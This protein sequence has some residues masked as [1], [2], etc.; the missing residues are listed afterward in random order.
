MRVERA[1]HADGP[2]PQAAAATFA[3]VRARQL[4][5]KTKRR[6][7]RLVPVGQLV[8]AD[9]RAVMALPQEDVLLGQQRGAGR[10][11]SPRRRTAPSSRSRRCATP[12]RCCARTSPAAAGLPPGLLATRALR[13]FAP[14]ASASSR[15][16]A[17]IS[18][19]TARVFVEQPADG[20][21]ERLGAGGRQRLHLDVRV[22]ARGRVGPLL[23][24]D[25]IEVSHESQ[26]FRAPQRRGL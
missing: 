14:G 17:S 16:R 21:G 25:R 15:C 9:Q 7:Q 3:S 13:A 12:G 18:A 20:E 5:R 10:P 6:R 8:L 1:D 19:T 11:C 26:G 2:A 4:C 22:L 24:G 23:H